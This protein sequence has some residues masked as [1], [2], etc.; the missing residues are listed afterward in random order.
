MPA[1]SKAQT[2]GGKTISGDGGTSPA[3]RAIPKR[4]RAGGRGGSSSGPLGHVEAFSSGAE[5]ETGAPPLHTNVSRSSF[6][7][8]RCC[9]GFCTA[10]VGRA[11]G[12]KPSIFG[13]G[14]GGPVSDSGSLFTRSLSH[15]SGR[16]PRAKPGSMFPRPER[17]SGDSRRAGRVASRV[18]RGST[19]SF[20][21]ACAT[22]PAPPGGGEPQA[23]TLAHQPVRVRLAA[24]KSRPGPRGLAASRRCAGGIQLAKLEIPRPA[25]ASEVD[26]SRHRAFR[27]AQVQDVRGVRLSPRM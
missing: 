11:V 8:S 7:R 4:R 5:S 6:A 25:E 14:R 9:A 10:D 24:P 26:H 18:A 17:C 1:S 15:G 19:H 27:P 23:R 22:Q 2:L 12:R 13:V 3:A 21:K 16:A 20:Q